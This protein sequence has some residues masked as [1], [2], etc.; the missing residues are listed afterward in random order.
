LTVAGIGAQSD[1]RPRLGTQPWS[2]KIES[3][4]T[5]HVVTAAPETPLKRVA[6]MLTRYRISGVPIVDAEGG[7]LG[8]VTEADILCKEQGLAPEPGGLLGWLFEKADAEGSRLLARTAGEAMTTPPVMISPDA[9]IS[10]AARIMVTRH[11][12]RLPVVDDGRLV[13]IISRA[14]LVRA[15]HRSDQE[16]RHELEE[17]VLLHQLWVSTEDV[18]VSVTDGV[19]ELGGMVENRTQAELVAAYA[20]RVPGV[21][22][23][24]SSVTWRVDDQARR[25]KR[26][27]QRL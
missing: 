11:I 23:V 26:I 4:M 18:Q 13:G 10:E 24:I 22:D 3:L 2:M 6:R 14:D 5:K 19:V 7:V 20:L 15:F 16:I 25:L 17:D 27:P 21:V 9:S 1:A 8:V 12:N